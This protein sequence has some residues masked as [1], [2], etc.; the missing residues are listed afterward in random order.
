MGM[1]LSENLHKKYPS[2]VEGVEF[3]NENKESMALDVRYCMERG[4][5]AL[6]RDRKLQK[7]LQAIQ[8][9]ITASGNVRF[10]ADRTDAIG[11]ADL[12]WALAL[13]EYAVSKGEKKKSGFYSKIREKG[14]GKPRSQLD[15]LKDLRKGRG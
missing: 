1:H 14:G 8:K 3:T 13:A 15:V 10:D 11:H 7:N 2:R 4:N 5:Y 12:F 9:T 6:P